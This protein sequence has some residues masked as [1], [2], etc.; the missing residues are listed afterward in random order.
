MASTTALAALSCRPSA[1]QRN[2]AT[3]GRQRACD[4]SRIPGGPFRSAIRPVS[5]GTRLVSRVQVPN[6]P[7][8]DPKWLQR[9]I[10]TLD[11]AINDIQDYAGFLKESDD[12]KHH[13]M[14]V[15]VMDWLV[16]KKGGLVQGCKANKSSKD[17]N[18]LETFGRLVEDLESCSSIQDLVHVLS[19]QCHAEKGMQSRP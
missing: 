5:R 1:F 19:C 17:C 15:E 7:M 4:A 9:T 11:T 14:A 16:E 6:A 10:R 2:C 3:R 12:G 18:T 8:E 13:G